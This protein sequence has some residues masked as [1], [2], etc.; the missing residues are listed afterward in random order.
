LESTETKERNS[1]G[2]LLLRADA[3]PSIGSGHVMRCLALAQEWR[4]RGGS[5]VFVGVC[6][7]SVTRDLV[8]K[9]D[10]F[11]LSVSRGEEEKV[12]PDYLWKIARENS[13]PSTIPWICLDGY[14][15][16]P[17]YQEEFKRRGFGV[18]V[19]DDMC[20][21][22]HYHA[23]V[24]LNQNLHSELLHYQCDSDTELLLGAPYVLL[25]K[26]FIHWQRWR[27]TIPTKAQRVLVTLGGGSPV[28]VL[29]AIAAAIES[30]RLSGLEVV[31]LSGSSAKDLERKIRPEATDNPRFRFLPGTDDMPGLMAWADVAVSAGGSTCWELAFMG[32]PG[33]V[34]ILADNQK[35]VARYMGDNGLAQ[36]VGVFDDSGIA[37][38]ADA[39]VALIPDAP[40]RIRM[41]AKGRET[42][43]G[44]GAKR[45]CEALA[46]Q[47]LMPK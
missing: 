44:L 17:S 8:A 34:G 29:E 33:I 41:S 47:R 25:R 27:R 40:R 26:E 42:I 11:L 16:D 6:E 30:T 32:L 1:C 43:D 21:L 18:L 31:M 24:V 4:D 23:H 38:I 10:F 12:R 46:T 37:E 14:H 22:P 36:N 3:S 15:F 5:A 19:I 45:V 9:Q 39:L 28:R 20:H 7:N 13:P 2:C 35:M